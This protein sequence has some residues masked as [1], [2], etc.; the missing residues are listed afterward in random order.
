MKEYSFSIIIPHK[1]C[2]ELLNQ[3]VASIPERDDIQIIVVDDNSDEGKKPVISRPGGE[4]VLLDAESA[5]GAGRARNV[6]LEKAT[7]KWLI[8]SDADDTFETENLNLMLDK[9]QYSE[10]D[11]IF[12]NANRV[13]EQTGEVLSH[14]LSK[15]KCDKNED[16]YCDFLRYW[17]NVPWAKFI[18]RDIIRRHSISFSEVPAAND[19]FFSTVS[20]YYAKNAMIDFTSIYNYSVRLTGNIT[21][22]VSKTSVLS[23]LFEASKRNSFLWNKGKQDWCINLYTA[24]YW[25]LRRVSYNHNGAMREIKQCITVGPE[26]K[27]R[28]KLLFSWPFTAIRK[29]LH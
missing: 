12:F 18:K 24:F 28:L 16:K 14:H 1:N 3:C 15:E 2:P 13:D 10:A 20:G 23:R 26:L 27:W 22:R 17:S 11:I 29:K 9:Y 8:F 19:L 21:S 7:G 6:G 4:V 5:K 25:R